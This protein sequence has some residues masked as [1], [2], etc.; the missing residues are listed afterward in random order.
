MNNGVE[1]ELAKQI[2]TGLQKKKEAIIIAALDYKLGKGWTQEDVKNR[3]KLFILSDKTEIFSVDGE[4][5]IEFKQQEPLEF[6]NGGWQNK[7]KY[8]LLY[9]AK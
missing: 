2:A 8:R 4:D 6:I 3:G 5:L 7:C 9:E 1:Q